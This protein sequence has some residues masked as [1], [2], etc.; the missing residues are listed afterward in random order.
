MSKNL[1]DIRE[2]IDSIDNQVH[3]L[4]MR[5][6]DLVSSV[7][8]AKKLAGLQIVHP[9][10]EAKLI[11]RLLDRHSGVLPRS[12]I[13]RIWRELISSVSL[14]QTGLSVVV[15]SSSYWDIAKNYFGSE[16]P[17]SNVSSAEN[18][19]D[20]VRG[21]GVYFAVMPWTKS[22][23]DAPWWASLVDENNDLSIVCALPYGGDISNDSKKALVVS[24]IDFMS[25]DNDISFIGVSLNNNIN[26]DIIINNAKDAG[27]EM[28][29]IF[30]NKSDNM[31]LLEVKGFVDSSSDKMLA[32]CKYL[33]G[34]FLYCGVIGGYPVITI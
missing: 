22:G 34:N 31:Y 19:L 29:N 28:V 13:V 27:F 30:S 5:R 33:D 21:N 9:A 11:R 32:L 18:A 16:T 25:S 12:T 2:E 1:S 14:L 6:A 8:A 3:D 23:E 24:K 7:S 20:E 15:S 26:R 17:M 10:R 4:F